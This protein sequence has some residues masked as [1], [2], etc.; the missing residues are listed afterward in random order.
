MSQFAFPGRF[1]F[2]QFDTGG[3]PPSTTQLT[4]EGDVNI[5]TTDVQST[6]TMPASAFVKSRTLNAVKRQR[7]I[8][9]LAVLQSK[10]AK[11]Q[12]LVSS[13]T[14]V[15][16]APPRKGVVSD[17]KFARWEKLALNVMSRQ[18]RLRDKKTLW[19][20]R[21]LRL[22]QASSSI[23]VK[24]Q[25][26]MFPSKVERLFVAQHA[27]HRV[28]SS[29]PLL[30]GSRRDF[31]VYRYPSGLKPDEPWQRTVSGMI[32][33]NEDFWISL[34]SQ[35]VILGANGQPIEFLT[36]VAFAV[37]QLADIATAVEKAK[38]RAR[39]RYFETLRGEQPNVGTM[40]VEADKTVTMI[41]EILARIRGL[42]SRIPH[43]KHPKSAYVVKPGA[44]ES[45]TATREISS[46]YLMEH[47]GL[48]PL[49]SDLQQSVLMLA[50]S[51][52]VSAY[53]QHKGSAT[54]YGRVEKGGAMFDYTVTA[55]YQCRF[56]IARPL[57]A[58]LA[59]LGLLNPFEA[60]WELTPGSYLVD[61]FFSVSNLL[62]SMTSHT[63][64]TFR[65]GTLATRIAVRVSQ[66]V[67]LKQLWEETSYAVSG[68]TEVSGS[69]V[70]F[71]DEK[72][73][74]LL[75]EPPSAMLPRFKNP[76][77]LSHGVTSV[78]LLLQKLLK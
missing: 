47:F 27:Y 51:L 15:V 70:A 73:R 28:R 11:T 48:S 43:S 37:R 14:P 78:A 52:G 71:F 67:L 1:R 5:I 30:I 76:V 7:L 35:G 41:R 10:I 45:R 13:A 68:V 12:K 50:E 9:H 55:R 56:D 17:N 42:L 31:Y 57:Y 49:I 22:S 24:L 62:E 39:L 46:A 63:G 65:D 19:E 40:S 77:S 44:G 69:V 64:L 2:D 36:D 38:E 4:A 54:E 21:L 59:S 29:Q 25:D 26:P 6:D 16:P 34:Y 60:L 61:W 53:V 72:D 58:D 74:V 3:N 75:T 33:T 32:P 66:P 8:Q 18:M 23:R 20:K